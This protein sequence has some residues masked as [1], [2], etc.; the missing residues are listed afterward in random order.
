MMLR[1]IYGVEI[2]LTFGGKIVF[3][4]IINDKNQ[5]IYLTLDQFRLLQKWVDKNEKEILETWN[6]GIG[7]DEDF[8]SI[9]GKNGD[10][11]ED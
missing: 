4:Q 6:D 10:E 8:V 7:R 1:D 11:N 5:K 2:A 3:E 9:L